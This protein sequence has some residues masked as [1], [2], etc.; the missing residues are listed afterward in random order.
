MFHKPYEMC[1][2]VSLLVQQMENS[3]FL[4][5]TAVQRNDGSPSSLSIAEKPS[6]TET[7]VTK[8]PKANFQMPINRMPG[9]GNLYRLPCSMVTNDEWS[10]AALDLAAQLLGRPTRVTLLKMYKVWIPYGPKNLHHLV[11]LVNVA[12]RNANK[13][14]R[15][16]SYKV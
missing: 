6:S 16:A 5:T 2:V 7:T 3:T 10:Q 9:V 13:K 4:V 14:S 15:S 11:Y 1:D 12:A 8:P